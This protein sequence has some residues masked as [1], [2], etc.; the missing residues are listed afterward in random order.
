[1]SYI[2]ALDQ[3][4]T[5]SRALI[6]DKKGD[7]LV[8]AQKEFSQFFP[9]PGWVEHDPMEIW[10]SQRD[11][12]I[13]A[14]QQSSLGAAD[15][16]AIGIANQRESTIVWDRATGIPLYKCIVWQDRRTSEYC[17]LLREKG[18]EQLFN[19]KTGLVLDPYFSG[20]KLRWILKNIPDANQK[21]LR[22]ELAF[23]TVDSW[24]IWQLTEG[25]KHITD[26]TNASRTLLFNIHTCDWDEELLNI[27]E[28][29]RSLLPTVC[30]SSEVYGESNFLGQPVS[31][32]GI[33][34]DQQA[35]LFGQ[36]CLKPGEAK[37]T[38]GTGAFMLMHTGT[39]PVFSEHHLLT[40]MACKVDEN[41]QYALEGSV[42]VAGAVVQWLRD[43]L[44]IINTSEEIEALA[45]S[46]PDNDGVY[47]VPA[48]T[49]L[50][51]PHWDPHVRGMI[52][53]LTRGAS[54][55]HIARAALESIAFQ[56]AD[57]LEAMQLDSK[58]AFT[59]LKVDG[60]ASTNNLLMQFQANLIGVP[61]IR[62]KS[63]EV[64]GLG[65][66]YLAGLAVRFWENIDEIKQ[67]RKAD[68]QF[69]PST[70]EEIKSLKDHW[71][72]ALDCAQYW[73]GHHES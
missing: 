11:V 72:R 46:V 55:A 1:M 43:S 13:K 67:L 73:E 42:F 8:S 5:S 22:G 39:T 47:F 44:G 58:I 66:A 34:G 65:A 64:T 24:L 20:T 21:A 19:Q 17:N 51:A 60:G 35:A 18:M 28:I 27:L 12:A 14:M 53:G 23:G 6:I 29:P 62:P 40:T 48:F 68:R 37:T 10:Q 25:K 54:K 2:L 4:T 59:N 16:A 70:D 32:S 15:I 41:K 45:S 7:I 31:I 61:V 69:L 9:T 57:V 38:Y 3:G 52:L 71:K 30:N 49:G 36:L 56:V 33:A 63:T 26:V 50:G